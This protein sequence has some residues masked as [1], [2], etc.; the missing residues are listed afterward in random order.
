MKKNLKH[1]RKKNLI[2]CRRNRLKYLINQ[3]SPS[4]LE[5]WENTIKWLPVTGD[6]R[7]WDW[8]FILILLNSKLKFCRDYYKEAKQPSIASQINIAIKLINAAL[9]E[10]RDQFGNVS[11]NAFQDYINLK[12]SGNYLSPEQKK[13]FDKSDF[14]YKKSLLLENKVW[15]ILWKYLERYMRN[16]WT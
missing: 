10:G 13:L 8:S 16:W 5:R 4:E 2:Q 7:C 6:D 3:A 12:N 1:K 15:I 11:D 9:R 14:Y